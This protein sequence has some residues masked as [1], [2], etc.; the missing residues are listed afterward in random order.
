MHLVLRLAWCL[1]C[2]YIEV[3]W[4][5]FSHDVQ[6]RRKEHLVD[7]SD[8]Q[9]LCP[10][11]TSAVMSVLQRQLGIEALSHRWRS[12]KQQAVRG[13]GAT[14]KWWEKRKQRHP[15]F[16]Y[17]S[18]FA[19]STGRNFFWTGNAWHQKRTTI[20]RLVLTL[21]AH[22]RMHARIAVTQRCKG[23]KDSILEE[24]QGGF[25]V[26]HIKKCHRSKIQD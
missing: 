23:H 17:H 4:D 21:F 26:F 20:C 25:H 1:Q 14:S 10:K 8:W 7:N 5:F 9:G 18:S 24:I 13:D 11:L 3:E 15:L 16:C 19:R 22:C 2:R 6:K 12:H